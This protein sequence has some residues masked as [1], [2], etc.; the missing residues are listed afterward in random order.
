MGAQVNRYR[1]VSHQR[2]RAQT[3]WVVFGGLTA[4]AVVIAD[5][6]PT[7]LFPELVQPGSLYL[8]ASALVYTLP[9]I[10]FS[11]CLGVAVLRHRLYDIDV[12]LR[13]TLIY[14]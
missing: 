5:F 7:F 6:T 10:L 2:E 13:R 12:I 9:I 4:V 14:L 3:R 11:I 8:L 1:V